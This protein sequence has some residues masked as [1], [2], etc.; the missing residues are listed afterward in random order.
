MPRDRRWAVAAVVALLAGWTAARTAAGSDLATCRAITD[1]RDRLACY[2]ALPA[3]AASPRTGPIDPGLVTPGAGPAPPSPPSGSWPLAPT[4]AD[5]FGR[6]SDAAA[7]ELGTAAGV[8]PLRELTARLTAVER[9]PDGRLLLTLDNGQAWSQ[10]DS[11]RATLQAGDEVRI[12]RAA[13]GS[14]L[15]SMIDDRRSALRVRRIR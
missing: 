11:R 2:D 6:S 3:P 12:R 1:D 8:V 14:Y 4:P 9:A 7:A 10:V 15:L 13:F 5:L